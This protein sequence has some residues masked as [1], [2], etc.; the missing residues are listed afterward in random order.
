MTV[1]RSRLSFAIAALVLSPLFGRAVFVQSQAKRPVGIQ[2]V[3]AWKVLGS[4]V[5]SNDGQWFAY[6]LAPQEGEA[7]VVVKLVGGDKE[8]RLPIGEV[9]PP[10]SQAPAAGGRGRGGAPGASAPIAFSDDGKWVAFATYPT[11]R[12]TERLKRQRRPIESGA[13]IVN[14]A[15]GEKHEFPRIR[16]FAFSGELSTWIALHRYGAEPPQGSA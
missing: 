12:D 3:V 14:L 13:T 15:T 10:P 2:D 1:H 11:R 5:L 4:A 8:L 7:E 9:P 16:K 6:R